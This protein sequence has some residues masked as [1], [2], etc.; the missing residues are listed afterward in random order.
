MD[1]AVDLAAPEVR[2]ARIDLA[3]AFR[4]C[5]R[6]GLIEGVANHFSVQVPGAPDLFLVNPEGLH[7]SEL[8]AR[9]LIVVDTSGEKVAGAGKLRRVAFVLHGVMHRDAPAARAILH[10]HPPYGAAITMLRGYRISHA[11]A[12]SG[13]MWGRFS[14]M[15]DFT[16]PLWSEDIG[17]S[18]IKA[19]GQGTIL[20]MAGHGVTA[21]GP[22]IA[23]AFDDL[24]FTERL[25][26]LELAARATGQP[27][28]DLPA[29]LLAKDAWPID[30]ERADARLHFDAIK[31][32]LDR[33]CPD[34]R[35]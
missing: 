7:W 27:L 5:G 11:H 32:Q 8:T 29:D 18:F 12:T 23:S 2:Q 25:C 19:L 4:A 10:C 21:V 31:R 14:Y 13:R 24:Y 6:A 20:F 16:G 34:Y 1:I 15:D 33:E 9:D 35:E 17:Q 30:T 28:W 3:A 22:T 26:R